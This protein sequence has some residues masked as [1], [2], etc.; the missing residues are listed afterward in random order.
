VCRRTRLRRAPPICR[1]CHPRIWPAAPDLFIDE[2][3]E[4]ARRLAH[5][6]IPLELHVYPGAFDLLSFAS[7]ALAALRR[8]LHPPPA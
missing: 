5:N 2:N 1:G 7:V 3:L 4:Y 8:F 6:G